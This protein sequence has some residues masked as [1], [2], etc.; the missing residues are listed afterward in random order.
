LKANS[1]E[2]KS[3]EGQNPLLFC[4]ELRLLG[5]KI[6]HRGLELVVQRANFP[7][8]DSITLHGVDIPFGQFDYRNFDGFGWANP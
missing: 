1:F 3:K 5:E 2:S 4:N 6:G 7:C 8:V